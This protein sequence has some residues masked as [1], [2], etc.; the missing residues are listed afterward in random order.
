MLAKQHRLRKTGD[1]NYVLRQGKSVSAGNLGLKFTN[2]QLSQSRF[3]FLV[4]SKVFRKASLRNQIKRKM[5]EA[6]RQALGS[7]QPG[8]DILLIARPGI[9]KNSVREVT[10]MVFS[11]LSKI[12][13]DT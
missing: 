10:A 12:K 4:A 8:K 7:V 13:W 11:A 2:N 6:A 1:F 5:R 9:E 3:G